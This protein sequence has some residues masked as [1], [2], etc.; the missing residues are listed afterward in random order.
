MERWGDIPDAVT[1]AAYD[2]VRFI[3]PG[4]IK[5]ADT[6]ETQAVIAALEQ[7]DVET[8]TARHFTFTSS[9]DIMFGPPDSA[10]NNML[11]CLF[12]WQDGALVPVYPKEIMDEAGTT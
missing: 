5:R 4:A 8:S 10:P 3:L 7:T 1:V 9:H 12:Q 2:T 11:D 6:T